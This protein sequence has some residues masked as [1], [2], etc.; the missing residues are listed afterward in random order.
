M[1]KSADHCHSNEVGTGLAPD[2]PLGRA[3]RDLAGI[4]NQTRRERYNVLFM[5]AGLALP[6]KALPDR[7]PETR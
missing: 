7:R 2:T 5:V 3:C 6:L 1:I 4:V